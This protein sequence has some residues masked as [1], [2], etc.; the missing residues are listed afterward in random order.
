MPIV[1]VWGL[2]ADT[3]EQRLQS[4]TAEFIDD[5]CGIKELGLSRDQVTCFFPSDIMMAGLGEE[6][7]IFVEGLFAKP[8]RTEEVRD[9]LA[10]ALGTTAQGFFPSA[11]TIE[12]LVR[13]FDPA[14]GFWTSKEGH[15]NYRKRKL[16]EL[17]MD[18]N[19]FH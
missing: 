16:S 9:R 1:M 10:E 11:H 14:Q 12:V 5:F 7:I 3:N 17:G 13:P 4:I 18:P 19:Q 8:E 2:P 15:M 6:I